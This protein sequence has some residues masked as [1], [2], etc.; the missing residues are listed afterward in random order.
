MYLKKNHNFIH[1]KYFVLIQ[2]TIDTINYKIMRIHRN[3]SP[4]H[5]YK[6]VIK[7]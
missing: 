1:K 3:S 5:T 6:E 7:K 4:N 2:Q